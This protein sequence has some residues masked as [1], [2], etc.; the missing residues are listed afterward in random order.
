M[1][2]DGQ[3]RA[4]SHTF[5]GA[6]EH[7]YSSP[8][9]KVQSDAVTLGPGGRRM[10]GT[11]ATTL[12]AVNATST[13]LAAPKKGGG[14]IGAYGAEWITEKIAF[15]FEESADHSLRRC[16]QK[17]LVNATFI[18]GMHAAT[19]GGGNPA[20]VQTRAEKVAMIRQ[21]DEQEQ[22]L[23][24]A[25]MVLALKADSEAAPPSPPRRRPACG[26]AA[27]SARPVRSLCGS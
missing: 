25:S 21:M 26:G 23:N 8:N 10:M 19:G 17:W 15:F 5:A 1:S 12:G 16:L 24:H 2:A 3:V 9:K 6:G 18:A 20:W 14:G 11:S 7:A 13:A 22:Q 27:A 4:S